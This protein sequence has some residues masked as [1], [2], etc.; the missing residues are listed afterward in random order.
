VL[1]DE[2]LA[3]CNREIRG[4]DGLFTPCKRRK[5]D[6]SCSRNVLT[7]IILQM[8]SWIPVHTAAAAI[9]EMRFSEQPFL[10]LAHPDPVTWD[11]IF[12]HFSTI[13]NVPIVEYEEWLAKLEEAANDERAFANNP[14]VHLLH[15]FQSVNKPIASDGSESLGFP[16]VETSSAVQVAPS[17]RCPSLGKDDVEMWVAYWRNVGFLAK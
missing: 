3:S 6:L 7:N 17:M 9:V 15:F 10:H 8:V 11:S 2:G 5:W 4:D 1:D 14:A 13:L 12:R 16:M